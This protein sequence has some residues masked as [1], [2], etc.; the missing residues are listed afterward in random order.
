M[1]WKDDERIFLESQEYRQQIASRGSYANPELIRSLE[2]SFQMNPNLSP[3]KITALAF[4]GADSNFANLLAKE[5]AK[6]DFARGLGPDG[7]SIRKEPEQDRDQNFLG[8]ARGAAAQALKLTSR[9]AFTIFD[10]TMELAQSSLRSIALSPVLLGLKELDDDMIERFGSGPV[11]YIN[12]LLDIPT[13]TSAWVAAEQILSGDGLGEILTGGN[14]DIGSGYFV[15]GSVEE[16]QSQRQRDILGTIQRGD[17]LHAWTAGRQLA[18]SLAD[19]G[20][21]DEESWAWN[22]A[23][24]TVDAVIAIVADPS[25]LI[26]GVGWGDEII[27]GVKAVGS[28]KVQKYVDLIERADKIEAA[29][30]SA[31]EVAMLRT[32]ALEAIGANEKF[33][34][35]A[36]QSKLS[37][38]E[39]LLRDKIMD[40]AGLAFS[41]D[42]NVKTVNQASFLSFLTQKSGRRLVDKMVETTTAREVRALH[43]N[44]IGFRAATDIADAR[45]PEEV[46]SIYLRAVTNPGEDA[47]YMVGAVPNMG[48]FRNSEAG[49]WVRNNVNAYTKLGRMLPEDAILA[50]SDG[51]KYVST[52]ERLGQVLPMNVADETSGRYVKLLQDELIEKAIR[53]FANGDQADI[54]ALTDEVSL[55]LKEMFTALGYTESQVDSLTKWRSTSE[56][57]RRFAMTTLD[58]GEPLDEIPLL[59]SQLITGNIAVINPAAFTRTLRDAGRIK[60]LLRTKYP[61]AKKWHD[62]NDELQ[63]LKV[64]LSEIDVTDA[65]KRTA[66]D[67]EINKAQRELAELRTPDQVLPLQ[68]LRGVGLAGDAVMSQVWKPLQLVRAA[69]IARV[70]MEESLRTIASGTFGGRAGVWDYIRASFDSNS[71]AVDA[72]GRRWRV[73]ATEAD[74]LYFK[75]ADLTDE[76][77]NMQKALKAGAD[78]DPADI[79][80]LKAKIREVD[81]QITFIKDELTEADRFYRKSQLNKN[82]GEAYNTLAKK[83]KKVMYNNR[84]STIVDFNQPREW[85][86]GM[87]AKLLKYHD[88]IILRQL[89]KGVRPK[90][91]LEI[92]GVTRKAYYW[93]KVGVDEAEI[94]SHWLM[95][96]DQGWEA[97]KKISNAYTV[98]GQQFDPTNFDDVLAWTNRMTDEILRATGGTRDALGRI[99]NYDSDIL[100]VIKTGRFSG[101]D[102]VR[103]NLDQTNIEFEPE[104]L[105]KL[106]E[107]RQLP[108]GGPI[109]PPRTVEYLIPPTFGPDKVNKIEQ[110][111]SFFFSAMYGTASD[112]L[113]RS[114]TFRRVY[115]KQMS[116]LAENMKPD[117]AQSV[118]AAA[119]KAGI[120]KKLIANIETKLR[121]SKG[122]ATFK[123]I[124]DLAKGAALAATRDLLFDAAK[125]GAGFDQMRLIM[126][127]GDAWKEVT[128]TWGRLF[129]EQ[130]GANLFRGMRNGRAAM[131]ADAG[132]FGPG[133]LYGIDEETGEQTALPDGKRE[134]W[135]YTDKT[136]G[137]K[138]IQLAGSRQIS[139]L[140]GKTGFLGKAVEDFTGVG[141]G[142]PL[143]NLSM[144]G[145]IL[146]G[147]GPIADRVVNSLI[148]DDPTYDWVREALFPFGAPADPSTPGGKQSISDVFV[149][150]WAKKIF[151]AAL[152]RE[153]F[154]GFI[155]NLINDLEDDPVF[156]S[157]MSQI[158]SSLVSTGN[159]DTSEVG[160]I[161]AQEDAMRIARKVHVLRGFA[162]FIGPGSPLVEYMV[163]TPDGDVMSSLVL[164][165]LRTTEELLI[166]RGQ[167]PTL[168]LPII[169]ETYGPDV[170]LLAAPN[171]QS[172]YKGMSA[173]DSWWDWYRTDGNGDAVKAYGLVGGFF[174]PD[175]GEFSLNA[176]SSM[177]SEGL[178]KALSMKE[179][180][181]I[182][183]RALGFIAYNRVR[184]ALP[185]ES[186]RSNMDTILLGQTRQNIEQHF[187]LELQ[188]SATV[189]TRRKQINQ[190]IQLVEAADRGEPLAQR[191][192]SQ[193]MGESLRIYLGARERIEQMA[194]DQFGSR[195]WQ[196]R[197]DGAYMREFM[198]DLGQRLSGQDP[199]FSKMFQYVFD[200]EM[201]EDLAVG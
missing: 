131:G 22:V 88:D 143:Q 200:G 174:G 191:L 156:V 184:D 122:T 11:G 137:Q 61:A 58:A 167:S 179:R 110:F 59:V 157:T 115:W 195:N 2:T 8:R 182:A 94:F 10:T 106:D 128:Q 50:T 159:Y 1:S 19:S 24:G 31:A 91:D 35:P 62:K 108:E 113:A 92:G 3:E 107:F 169:M 46:V 33:L 49:L 178:S 9:T 12:F 20:I 71:Y 6:I 190:A 82:P 41:E 117:Q 7:E 18:R 141:F 146:P 140:I 28:K 101:K 78:I 99:I 34:D 144:A 85:N 176:Y 40:E 56:G 72:A 153:G 104:F 13:G 187:N 55:K 162:Q 109:Q 185:P 64:E 98:R 192:M 158:Y 126:P 43:K 66:K 161:K 81:D 149:P 90:F 111:I 145:D 14:L 75:K 52:L 193:P 172:E 188:S 17:D 36:R 119:R 100:E 87:A 29:G 165:H 123:E 125:R 73:K 118:L 69:F 47:A 80:V 112:K 138:R 196:R 95:Q 132:P 152:P 177:R 120:D 135:I 136:T 26:P 150:S 134:P 148:P 103:K 60:E 181:D 133:D 51:N 67:I 197:R 53:T 199:M 45:T 194:I 27:K 116:E 147:V 65:A 5:Q 68:L 76:L 86:E 37:A 175:E 30:G 151:P 121:I 42:G 129:V 163:K 173:K 127:F 139:K 189:S 32:R 164:D 63:K 180:Y 77:D 142:V 21:I 54:Y 96:S 44:R 83:P 48:I 186:K 16:E 201:M 105:K 130:R 168:A 84:V 70:V 183:A 15:G 97:L 124:D 198:R 102:I 89:A 154:L 23:S 170:W 57:Y 171:S 74:E 39:V 155:G 38:N 93:Y 4:G 25:N 160:Q 166:A 79:D 114:P